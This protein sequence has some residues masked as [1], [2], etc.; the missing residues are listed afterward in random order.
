MAVIIAILSQTDKVDAVYVFLKKDCYRL[1]FFKGPLFR[2]E[3]P[4]KVVR[5]E[6]GWIRLEVDAREEWIKG[7][8]C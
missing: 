1:T 2:G 6:P 3:G 8:K 7:S 5:A 4:R